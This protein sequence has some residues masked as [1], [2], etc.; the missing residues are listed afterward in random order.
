M[1]RHRLDPPA[2]SAPAAA[3]NGHGGHRRRQ[4][5]ARTG[6]LGAS[7]AVAVGA[8]A[9]ATGLLPTPS[10]LPGGG[11]VLGGGDDTSGG[12]TQ[13]DGTPTSL[14]GG[15]DGGGSTTGGGSTAPGGHALS[16]SRGGSAA[17]AP[18]VSP[19]ATPG[20]TATRPGPTV[21]VPPSGSGGASGA[22]TPSGSASGPVT[23]VATATPS[24]QSASAVAAGEVL[25]LVNQARATAGCKPLTADPKLT[26]LAQGFSTEMGTRGFFDHTDPDGKSPWDRA[27]AL[28]IGNLAGENIARGQADA[29][30]VMTAWMHSPGHRANILSCDYHSIGIGVYYGPDGPWWTQDFGF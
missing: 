23:P 26:A 16:G 22:T 6:L 1:G 25:A 21:T 9:V 20:G 7:A 24:A 14:L 11:R 8:V 18:V 28:G 27:K 29:Q 12:L 2:P 19:T 10:G 30:A 3:P 13:A 4:H 17:P 5:P 15:P